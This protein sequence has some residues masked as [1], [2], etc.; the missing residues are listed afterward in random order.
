MNELAIIFDKLN[1]DFKK[2]L[3]AAKTK[4]NFINFKPGLVGGHCIGVD[5]YYL[6]YKSSITGYKPEIILSGRKIN[7]DM[8][9]FYYK[10]IS[11]LA[12]HKLKKKSKF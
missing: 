11:H 12:S 1:V 2:V 5:P 3:E 10:K 4:W 8:S 9:N 7:D 6:A